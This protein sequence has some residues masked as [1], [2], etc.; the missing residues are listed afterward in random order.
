MAILIVTPL[1]QEYD[2]LAGGLRDRGW[3]AEARQLARLPAQF[4]PELDLLMSRGGVGK[5]QFAVQTQYLLERAK[6]IHL[7]ICAGSAGALGA[8]VAIGDIVVGSATV[9]F[10]YLAKFFPV[11]PP[12]FPGDEK[13]IRELLALPLV[14]LSCKLHIG[15]IASGDETILE[16][17]RA[18]EV[19]AKTGA[20]ANGWEGA[21]GARAAAF[22]ELPFLELRGISDNADHTA[23]ADFP[24]NLARA[25]DNL[26]ALLDL[27]LRR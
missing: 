15:P 6:G 20:L 25:L 27:W 4:F 3:R 24:Q 17:S 23:T 19:R 16:C 26:A 1:Q 8:E 9:E 10:D 11:P 14:S 7:V 22:N 5:A 18:E 2:A 12:S 13:T 21:G